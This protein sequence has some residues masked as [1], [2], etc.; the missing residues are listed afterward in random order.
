M[1]Q[2]YIH[3]ITNEQTVIDSSEFFGMPYEE[4]ALWAQLIDGEEHLIT[5]TVSG[6]TNPEYNLIITTQSVICWCWN[7]TENDIYSVRR[8]TD[9]SNDHKTLTETLPD[10]LH[11]MIQSYLNHGT[12]HQSAEQL[13]LYNRLQK[14][15][16][17]HVRRR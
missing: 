10:L 16:K 12:Y 14:G 8:Y 17:K 2:S 5:T 11:S 15:T 1:K 13:D 3:I 6:K 4:I 7:E 9:A